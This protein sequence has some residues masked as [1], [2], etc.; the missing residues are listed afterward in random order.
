MKSGKQHQNTRF[1]IAL[2]SL[3]I[4]YDSC[5]IIA[6]SL[7]IFNKS[8]TLD[9]PSRKNHSSK[10]QYHEICFRSLHCLKKSRISEV[11]DGQSE[12]KNVGVEPFVKNLCLAARCLQPLQQENGC[13][14]RSHVYLI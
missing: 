8:H 6:A 11:S 3:L 12:C 1:I 9:Y 4:K 5:F 14:V 10:G 13:N 7:D 2:F